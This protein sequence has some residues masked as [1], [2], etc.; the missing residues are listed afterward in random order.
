[1]RLLQTVLEELV[2]LTSVLQSLE[3]NNNLCNDTPDNQYKNCRSFEV[4]NKCTM[5]MI[6]AATAIVAGGEEKKELKVAR[7]PTLSTSG[8][9]TITLT[10]RQRRSRL[11]AKVAP[12]PN[13]LDDRI[14]NAVNCC[15]TL[16][17][18]VAV[19]VLDCWFK[20]R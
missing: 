9:Q 13:S 8:Q 7:V 20:R 5:L 18:C 11:E 17:C 19:S 4:V 10:L 15:S 1:M 16:C 12:Q 6:F 14:D 2:M 3:R